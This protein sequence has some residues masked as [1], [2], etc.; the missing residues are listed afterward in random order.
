MADSEKDKMIAKLR[1]QV[2]DKNVS[3]DT[4]KSNIEKA[5]LLLGALKK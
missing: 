1:K 3:I 2:T 5:G 4:F